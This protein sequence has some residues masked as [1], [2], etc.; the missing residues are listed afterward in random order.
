MNFHFSVFKWTNEI[1]RNVFFHFILTMKIEWHFRCTD[2][3][4]VQQ[5][6]H[7][8]F[9][10]KLK[11]KRT[12]LCISISFYIWKLKKD[13]FSSIFN[14]QFLLIRTPKV[15]FNFHFKIRMAKDIFA[16]FIFYFK[17]ED[18]KTK[19][20]FLFSITNFTEKF[21]IENPFFVFQLSNLIAELHK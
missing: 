5:N 8:I 6:C 1:G 2:L 19:I 10:V 16:H 12:F 18:W 14:F 3:K 21:K 7:P 13:N 11:L 17:I 9:I 4:S 15:P 20:F